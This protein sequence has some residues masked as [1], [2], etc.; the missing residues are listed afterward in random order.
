MELDRS[1]VFSFIPR[2]FLDFI[3]ILAMSDAVVILRYFI[4]FKNS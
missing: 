3:A 2:G 4:E 1:L